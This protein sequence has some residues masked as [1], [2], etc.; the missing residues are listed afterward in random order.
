MSS[1]KAPGECEVTRAA[2]RQYVEG[3]SWDSTTQGQRQLF[4][5]VVHAGH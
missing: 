2:I 1:H 4:E 3:F 5:G